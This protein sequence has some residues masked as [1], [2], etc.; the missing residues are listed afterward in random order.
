MAAGAQVVVLSP[1]S[2]RCLLPSPTA[3]PC[4]PLQASTVLLLVGTNI[5]AIVQVGQSAS[6]AVEAQWLGSATWWT[7][8]NGTWPMVIFSE[9]AGPPACIWPRMGC[10]CQLQAVLGA[11]RVK[12]TPAPYCAGR[13]VPPGVRG[14]IA[15]AHQLAPSPSCLAP[16]L[17]ALGIVFPLSM[18]PSMRQ[19]EVAGACG[20][21]IVWVLTVCIMVKSI[22]N[23]LP[24]LGR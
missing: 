12:A 6:F 21:L 7:G 3:R 17:A 9:S 8:N 18:L 15:C 10:A 4:H 20:S 2:L 11:S 13:R 22:S 23:G 24:Q 1:S 5:G 14:S 16:P 19:L